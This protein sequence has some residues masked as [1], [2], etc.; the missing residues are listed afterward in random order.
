MWEKYG[1]AGLA[2]DDI[3]LRLRF[4][5]QITKATDTQSECVI[6]TAFQRQQ[7]FR[8]SA[9]LLRLYEHCLHCS[10]LAQMGVTS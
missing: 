5:C 4:A 9:S 1:K 3:I 6:L 8:E 2:T 7:L 10:F